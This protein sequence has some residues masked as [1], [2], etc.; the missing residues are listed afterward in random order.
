MNLDICVSRFVARV[1]LFFFLFNRVVCM[2][3]CVW[4][5]NKGYI[6][7]WQVYALAWDQQIIKW[8]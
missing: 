4:Y 6:L 8:D 2:N 3:L 7:V 1:C 5:L